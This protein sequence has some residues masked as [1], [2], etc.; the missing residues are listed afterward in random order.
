[1][2]DKDQ[3]DPLHLAIIQNDKPALKKLIKRKAHLN[4]SNKSELPP[5]HLA[6][7]SGNLS[8]IKFLIELKEDVNSLSENDYTPLDE[9]IFGGENTNQLINIIELLLHH[10]AKSKYLSYDQ[11]FLSG[12]IQKAAL[13]PEI[14]IYLA[15][16]NTLY[17]HTFLNAELNIF[18]YNRALSRPIDP[19]GIYCIAALASPYFFEKIIALIDFSN[20]YQF[21]SNFSIHYKFLLLRSLF[22]LHHDS[23][24]C[25]KFLADQNHFIEKDLRNGEFENIQSLGKVESDFLKK[26]PQQEIRMVKGKSEII[27][28]SALYYENIKIEKT[29]SFLLN[30]ILI[31]KNNNFFYQLP[32]D[33]F[34]FIMEWIIDKPYSLTKPS[35]IF[36]AL[37]QSSHKKIPPTPPYHIEQ[38]IGFFE[39]LMQREET[40]FHK[41]KLSV[42]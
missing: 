21:F 38:R 27:I 13:R 33:I 34:N 23:E 12:Y 4:S 25:A 40:N 11:H 1:M 41:R 31:S 24:S 20:E 42:G 2:P 16:K 28:K 26:L 14:K 32:K 39:C 7:R 10:S 5:L 37:T 19:N 6:V 35:Q 9:A 36:N 15:F 30:L 22:A 3:Q 18:S 29:A 8:M 17:H